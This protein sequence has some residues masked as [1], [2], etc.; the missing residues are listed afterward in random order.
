MNGFLCFA[1][2][3][4]VLT[5]FTDLVIFGRPDNHYI[6]HTLSCSA[7]QK[8]CTVVFS[9]SCVACHLAFVPLSAT[10]NDIDLE[11]R[12]NSH[13]ISTTSR[14]GNS[15]LIDSFNRF[16]SRETD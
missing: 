2:R 4:Y 9:R 14:V 12:R 10:K 13:N 7:M 3:L 1:L 5:A 6:I 8:K 16:S 11:H 15:F